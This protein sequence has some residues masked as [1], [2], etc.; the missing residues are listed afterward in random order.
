MLTM[1]RKGEFVNATWEEVDFD[2]ATWTI[3]KE[4]MK[5]GKPHVVYLSTQA[6]DILV[7]FKTCFGASRFLHPGRYDMD[8]PISNATLNRVI[9]VGVAAAGMKGDDFASFTVH[10]LRRTASTRL[11]EFGFNRDWIE[12]CLAHEGQHPWRLQQGRVWRAATCNAASMGGRDRR[13]VQRRQGHCSLRKN[14]CCGCG[15]RPNLTWSNLWHSRRKHTSSST[16]PTDW[17]LFRD[18]EADQPDIEFGA[19]APPDKD[20]L[21]PPRWDHWYQRKLARPWQA[22][23]LGMNFEPVPEIKLF[24]YPENIWNNP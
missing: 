5:T 14:L 17:K 18:R 15:A 1:V 4:R 6:L 19:E 10:D 23:L 22:T 7:T 11:N 13:L 16:L 3:P 12:K 20:I 21:V 2:N 9:E 24:P 8:T